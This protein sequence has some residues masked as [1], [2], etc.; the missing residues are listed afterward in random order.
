MIACVWYMKTWEIDVRWGMIYETP[1]THETGSNQYQGQQRGARFDSSARYVILL[2]PQSRFGD[3][4][5]K[6]QVVRPQNGTAVLR[7]L[8]HDCR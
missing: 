4:P 8:K 3:K 5:V 7:G 6:F 2:E 1:H